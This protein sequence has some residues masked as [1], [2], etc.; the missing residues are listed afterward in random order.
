[1]TPRGRALTGFARLLFD[2][3]V[4]ELS[5]DRFVWNIGLTYDGVRCLSPES[6]GDGEGHYP[7]GIFTEHPAFAHGARQPTR[8]K[9]IGDVG[10]SAPEKW[11][12]VYQADGSL[13]TEEFHVGVSRATEGR[14]IEKGATVKVV[15]IEGMR[16]VVREIPVDELKA[17]QQLNDQV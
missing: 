16:V 17:E 10:E 14:L 3:I 5:R 9:A 6:V 2:R 7:F 15:A 11:E 8:A 13:A 4:S 1:M 12:A